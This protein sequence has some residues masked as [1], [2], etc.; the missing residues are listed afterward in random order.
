M[1]P[2]S[3]NNQEYISIIYQLDKVKKTFR[4]YKRQGL[5]QSVKENLFPELIRIEK[6]NGYNTFSGFNNLLRL[7]DTSNWS[8]CTKLGLKPTGTSSFYHTD[9]FV[10]NKRNLCI[11][12][13]PKDCQLTE[14]S[15]FPKF[16]PC[17]KS[18]LAERIKELAQ[19]IA[20]KKG[21]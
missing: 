1:M 2:F 4:Q 6:N 13:Y 7:R 17:E 21:I 10:G 16:Y 19:S 12:W 11:V 20:H 5:Q 8:V 14:F 9:V 3:I 18:E 15:I